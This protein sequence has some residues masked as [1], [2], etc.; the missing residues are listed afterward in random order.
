M[1][2]KAQCFDA[3][4][5]VFGRFETIWIV[6]GWRGLAAK[7]SRFAHTFHIWNA[8]FAGLDS[9]FAPVS[10]SDDARSR[11]PENARDGG[12]QNH[13]Q[14]AVEDLTELRPT[15]GGGILFDR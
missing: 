6:E 8:C 10:L 7:H 4:E 11:T 5:P 14:E 1:N 2:P 13:L 9:D 12:L 15:G 3:F